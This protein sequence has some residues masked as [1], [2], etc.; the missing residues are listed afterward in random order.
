MADSL[1]K[2][3]I[4]STIPHHNDIRMVN[5]LFQKHGTAMDSVV[6]EFRTPIIYT[7]LFIL[8]SLPAA[9]NTINYLVPS[10]STDPENLILIFAKAFVFII[11]IYGVQHYTRLP[12][13]K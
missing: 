7:A 3:P 10:M 1:S 4:D 11:L 9:N 2:L 12:G 6:T 8:L 13:S 5:E